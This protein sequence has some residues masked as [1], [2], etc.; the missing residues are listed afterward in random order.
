M[1]AFTADAQG[2]IPAVASPGDP[3]PGG[4]TFDYAVDPVSNDGGDVAFAG[5][6]VSDPCGP[7]PA[8]QATQIGCDTNV[9]VKR[10]TSGQIET[11]VQIGD[12]L[13]GGGTLTSGGFGGLTSGSVGGLN[14]A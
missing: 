10:A 3:A 13:P 14:N 8:P 4:S 2:K 5:R 7:Q 9:Y 6:R 1:G 11:I 12:T